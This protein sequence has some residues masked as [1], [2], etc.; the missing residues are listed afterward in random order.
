MIAAAAILSPLAGGGPALA[1][2]AVGPPVEVDVSLSPAATAKLAAAKETIVVLADFFGVPISE[3]ERMAD[4]GRLQLAPEQ[5]IEIPGAGVAHIAGPKYQKAQ[6][7]LVEG[8]D[9]KIAVTVISARH[10]SPDNLLACDYFEESLKLAT[11]KPL[12]VN[13]K[14]ISEQ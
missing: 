10:S 2:T 3:K 6:L 9:V 14:L 8:G 4:Q 1:Q 11:S 13:C 7:K 12:K 5:S